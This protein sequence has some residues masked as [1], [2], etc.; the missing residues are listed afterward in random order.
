SVSVGGFA[1]TPVGS[2]L[3]ATVTI[4]VKPF[5]GTAFTLICCPMLPATSATVAGEGDNEKSAA[6]RSPEKLR[7]MQDVRGRQKSRDAAKAIS[8]SCWRRERKLMGIGSS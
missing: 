6:N 8:L 2:P 7:I 3:I 4:P 5:A 1:V